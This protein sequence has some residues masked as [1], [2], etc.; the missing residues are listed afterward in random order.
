MA[1]DNPK[2]PQKDGAKKAMEAVKKFRNQQPSERL[3]KIISEIPEME[4]D[5]PKK[6]DIAARDVEI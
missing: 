6:P 2:L 3:I 5:K 1:K 4:T